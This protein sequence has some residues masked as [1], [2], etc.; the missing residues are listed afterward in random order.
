VQFINIPG[1][2]WSISLTVVSLAVYTLGIGWGLGGW[3]TGMILGWRYGAFRGGQILLVAGGWL[4]S[5]IV[6]F[7][8]LFVL[9]FAVGFAPGLSLA[10]LLV[11]DNSAL[12]MLALVLVVLSAGAS[13]VA[14]VLLSGVL[15]GGIG[16]LV[17]GLALRWSMPAASRARTASVIIAW[18][19]GLAMAWLLGWVISGLAWAILDSVE[20]DFQIWPT[21]V[22]F[23]GGAV[24]GMVGGSLGGGIGGALIGWQFELRDP[25]V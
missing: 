4:A 19:I 14:G 17:T 10:G 1:P 25:H 11:G 2:K 13:F 22:M 8:V 21:V 16:S 3:C 24:G 9:I 7:P 5:G 23:A 20:L 12:N 6:A 15:V 18:A